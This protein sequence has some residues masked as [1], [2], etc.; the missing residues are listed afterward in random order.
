[1]FSDDNHIKEM[2]LNLTKLFY[3]VLQYW[4][5][6]PIFLTLSTAVALY[7][8]KSTATQYKI[9]T[10]L[11]ISDTN[12]QAPSISATESALPGINL[13][14]INN[15]E[16]QLIILTSSQQIEKTLNQL[17]F[18]ISYHEH[19]TFKEIEIYKDSPFT[20]KLDTSGVSLPER[21]FLIEFISKDEF[22]IAQ[23]DQPY[24]QR[25][26]FFEQIEIEGLTFA[27]L[28][29]DNTL[30]EQLQNRIF[31]FQINPLYKLIA[32][33]QKAI[34]IASVKS[35]SSI[36]EISIHQNN[37]QKGRD[38]LNKLAE[39]SVAYTLDKKNQIANNTIQFIE[40]QLI[41]VSDSLNMT[42]HMLENFRS[43]NE[44]MDISMQGQMIIDKT[45]NLELE[46]AIISR[47]LDYY[48]YLVN[49]LESNQNILNL[50]P[51]SAQGVE[52]LIVD[53]MVSEL[54]TMNAE[55]QSLQFNSKEDNPAIARINRQISGK[56][57]IILQQA[58]S[59][60]TS[61]QKD[62]DDVNQRL[63]QLSYEIRRLPQKEQ[64]SLD[65]EQKFQSTDRMHSYLMERRSEAQLAKASNT[66]DNEIIEPAKVMAKTKPDLKL[67]VALIVIVGFFI[68]FGI[69]FLFVFTNN[70]VLDKEDLEQISSLPIIGVIP[71]V[72]QKK[73]FLNSNTHS[74]LA[75]SIR[76]IRTSLEFYP[77]NGSSKC[78]LFTSGLPNEGKT[79]NAI[80]LAISYAQLGKKTIIVDFDMRRP[81]VV[82]LLN[83]KKNGYGL[84]AFLSQNNPEN[85]SKLIHTCEEHRLDVM[86]SGEIPPN[87]A[88]LIAGEQ[89]AV[90]INELKR[91]YEIIIIDSPPIG[92]VT[93]ALL[94]SRLSDINILV[95]RHKHTPKP[96]LTNLLKDKKITEIKNFNLV[97]NDLPV[98][99]RAYNNF[100]YSGKY[101]KS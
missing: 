43:R 58:K 13:G 24:S 23:D 59:N 87:P 62:L 60:I 7:I 101:Y 53:Q 77:N 78:I 75:E 17:N 67:M 56:K 76:N 16:N 93:D 18:G 37:I 3:R 31:S 49:F 54:A 80:N 12:E 97:L 79:T 86:V 20:V 9:S 72:S 38:F 94:L 65:I 19:E 46:K 73:L 41:D 64:V 100:S 33:Y 99:K 10:R 36:F 26:K 66:P 32:Y 28:P 21:K 92:L 2:P 45:E 81:S 40:N 44:M 48:H 90:L 35:G 83:I 70:R 22:I 27:L 95:T 84:S 29:N 30:N 98:T 96:M 89:T 91:L 6:I 74:V 47:Q 11:L 82:K 25:H 5:Y 88:E 63:I 1:M 14:T 57:E 34:N 85:K 15:V 8:Y 71:K 68:P 50:L 69:I 42:K 55:K 51:P 39:N 4:Y 61:T 52:N